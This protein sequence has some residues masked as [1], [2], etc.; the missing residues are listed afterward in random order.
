MSSVTT[1]PIADAFVTQR[2]IDTHRAQSLPDDRASTNENS[3]SGVD[4]SATPSSP[5]DRAFTKENSPSGGNRT[6]PRSAP[7]SPVLHALTKKQIDKLPLFLIENHL[8]SPALQDDKPA[9]EAMSCLFLAAWFGRFSGHYFS[10]LHPYFLRSH[11]SGRSRHFDVRVETRRFGREAKE[12]LEFDEGFLAAQHGRSIQAELDLGLET[13]TRFVVLVEILRYHLPDLHLAA[14]KACVSLFTKK[15][16]DKIRHFAANFHGPL[17]PTKVVGYGKKDIALFLEMR[18][19]V[20][21]ER[22]LETAKGD[23]KR[24]P[25]FHDGLFSFPDA[26]PAKRQKINHTPGVSPEEAHSFEIGT[27]S[28]SD[29]DITVDDL[30]DVEFC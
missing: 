2:L 24:P 14:T 21:K 6:A 19:R 18:S 22:A 30:S 16:T 10:S 29:D 15:Q 9:L 12:Y 20:Q 7:P 17:K 13:F 3:P 28:C 23:G 11:V 1:R 4:R 27:G 26:V 25:V 5:D 8:R